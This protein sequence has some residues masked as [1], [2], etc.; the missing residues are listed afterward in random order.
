MEGHRFKSGRNWQASM[1]MELGSK[2][3]LKELALRR[4]NH[5]KAGE[6]EMEMKKIEGL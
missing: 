2:A 5:P 1:G 6:K 3:Q 4:R